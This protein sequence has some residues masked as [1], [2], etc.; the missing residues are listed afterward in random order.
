MCEE[1]DNVEVIASWM[2]IS[3]TNFLMVMDEQK[4]VSGIITY[5][6]ICEAVRQN[7][8]N[9]KEVKVCEVMNRQP[10]FVYSYDDEATALQAMRK[11]RLG[12]LPVLN[13]NEQLFGLVSFMTIARRII[14]LK[15]RLKLTK[16]INP[17]KDNFSFLHN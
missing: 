7:N 6:K 8:W 14:Q 10:V 5:S 1:T 9:D 17:E 13:E 2:S 16:Q 12:Y 11:N 4:K 3:G 15:K